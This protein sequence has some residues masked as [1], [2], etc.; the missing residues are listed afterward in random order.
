MCGC[1]LA[2]RS[3]RQQAVTEPVRHIPDAVYSVLEP[4][5]HIPD[6]V[7]SVLDS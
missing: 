5:R 4:V 1:L 7:Y 3:S 6:A 2:G